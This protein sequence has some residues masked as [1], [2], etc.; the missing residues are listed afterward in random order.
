MFA[1]PLVLLS[2]VSSALAH[3]YVQEIYISSPPATFT[4]FLPWSDPYYVPPN[5]R[6]VRKIPSNFPINN[7][8]SIDIQC[9]GNTA[10]GSPGSAPSPYIAPV[11][12]GASVAFNWTEWP[13]SHAGPLITYMAKAPSDITKWSPDTAA[14]WFKI[15]EQGL[16]DGK[17][18]ATDILT[19]N[20]SIYT[21]KIPSTLKA[22]QYLIRHE[23]IA[24][25]GAFDPAGAQFYP[26]CTQVNVTGSGTALPTTGLVA[27]PGAYSPTDP[28]IL[29]NMYG[30]NPDYPIPG[31]AVWQG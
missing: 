5:Q 15:D 6:V 31:P 16:V 23:I 4:G 13:A 25:H 8:S 12:A 22:G 28:G 1:I 3:G 26:M 9:N 7:V 17:W 14:V 27:F 19:A 2:A 20:K 18:A 10:E 11:A 29:Y 30:G 24:L 21:F